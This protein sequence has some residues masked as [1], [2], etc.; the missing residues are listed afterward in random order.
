[1]K[2]IVPIILAMIFVLTITGCSSKHNPEK[3]PLESLPA[4]YSLEQAKEDGCIV[5]ES[6][7]ITS[8]QEIWDKFMKTVNAGK[9]ATV[10]LGFYYTL[11]PSKC[12]PEYYKSAKDDYPVLFIRDLIF[13]GT[14]YT[15]RGYDEGHENVKTYKYLMKYEGQAETPDAIY[16]S[17]VRYV[18][19]NNDTVTWE[20]IVHGIFSSS[21]DYIN[22]YVVY[23]DL[24]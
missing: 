5:Y 16:T 18:L 1:M 19:T 8:G 24:Y 7:D 15:I 17:Y 23:T 22:H 3:I 2:K 4:D 9:E 14:S 6:S 12:D 20:Q 11:D 13:D 21:G 10:R